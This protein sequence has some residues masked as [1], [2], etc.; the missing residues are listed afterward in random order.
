MDNLITLNPERVRGNVVLSNGNM[1]ARLTGGGIRG[2]VLAFNDEFPNF[3]KWY[4]EVKLEDSS[5]YTVIGVGISDNINPTTA[6]DPGIRGYSGNS[7]NKIPEGSPYGN[8]LKAGDILSVLLDL[9][10]YTLE[11]WLNG[12]SQGISHTDFETFNYTTPFLMCTSNQ[13]FHV[14]IATVNFGDSE[15]EYTPPI[16]FQAYSNYYHKYILMKSSYGEIL[17][18][19][20]Q[21]VE[22]LPSQTK[23]N[24]IDYGVKI[25]RIDF[26][27]KFK[28]KQYI[29]DQYQEL[30][31]GRIFS[32]TVNFDKYII[33][34]VE[35]E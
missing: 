16:G 8:P 11:F 5:A 20:N 28:H 26:R 24:F 21:V 4:W 12:V 1:T 32:H 23:Q 35:I 7:G 2:S 3:G 6:N 29:Q 9:D 13:T 14:V 22:S 18:V 31:D 19:K 33:N 15:F 30:G 25:S 10:N 27:N 34:K 17:T